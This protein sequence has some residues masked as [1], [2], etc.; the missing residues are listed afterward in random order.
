[1]CEASD[2]S[3]KP[4]PLRTGDP[5]RGALARRAR[6]LGLGRAAIAD[7]DLRIDGRRDGPEEG[8]DNPCH[9]AQH[10]EEELPCRNDLPVH[11]RATSARRPLVPLLTGTGISGPAG[12]RCKTPS[13]D[14]GAGQLPGASSVR[15]APPSTQNAPG[16]IS[17]PSSG[18]PT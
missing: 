4:P 12:Q 10:D 6:G 15:T 1:A 14:H 7:R 5:A 16:R 8:R 3:V 2:C 17:S 18:P 11:A 9:E 13:A